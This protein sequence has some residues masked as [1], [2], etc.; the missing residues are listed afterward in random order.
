MHLL[1]E[2][3]PLHHHYWKNCMANTHYKILRIPTST[4]FLLFIVNKYKL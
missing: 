3:Y 1:D 2:T 4:C